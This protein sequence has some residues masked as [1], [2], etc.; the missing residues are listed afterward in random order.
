MLEQRKGKGIRKAMLEQRKAW[1]KQLEP[2]PREQWPA[3]R[4]D[5]ALPIELFRSRDYL[6]QVYAEPGKC[7]CWV[8]RLSVCRV[9]LR[10]DGHWDEN[11][12]WDELMRC[13]REAGY[14]DWYGVEV[15]PRERDIVNDANMRHLW[16]LSEPLAIGWFSDEVVPIEVSI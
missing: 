11:I 14:G 1:P 9:T 7:S 12:S 13:K 2:V 8:R 16:L 3:E 4:G 5:R 10:A 15:Y 6:V